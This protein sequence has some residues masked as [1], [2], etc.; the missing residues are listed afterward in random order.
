MQCAWLCAAE[1]IKILAVARHQC[2]FQNL[3][4]GIFS[5]VSL[6]QLEFFLDKLL[7]SLNSLHSVLPSHSQRAH[8]PFL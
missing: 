7:H 2:K 4:C 5:S 3:D 8:R 1:R 6:L